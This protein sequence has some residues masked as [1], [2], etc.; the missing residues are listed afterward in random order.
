MRPKKCARPLKLVHF[1]QKS[2]VYIILIRQ[3]FPEYS[4]YLYICMLS[5]VCC[6]KILAGVESVNIKSGFWKNGCFPVKN[7]FLRLKNWLFSENE[8]NAL[9]HQNPQLIWKISGKL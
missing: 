6:G 2:L 3:G 4:R 8:K 7:Q 9:K 1:A 5:I